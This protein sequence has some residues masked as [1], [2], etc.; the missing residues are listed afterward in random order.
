MHRDLVGGVEHAGRRAARLRRLARQPQAGERLGVRRLERERA[1]LRE[2]ERRHGHV[3]AIGMVQR[4][5]DRHPHVGV[6]EVRERG[7][8]AEPDER[9]HDRLR[10]HDDVDPVVRRA[11]QP[12]RLDHLEALVHQ[13]RRVDRDLAAHRPGRVPERVLDADPRELGQAAAAERA[14]RG[15]QR[16][17]LDRARPLAIDQLVQRRVL[18]VDRDQLRAGRL[19]RAPSPARRRRRATPCW[20][21]RRRS[22]R[23]APRSSARGRRSPRSRSA[24]G[25]RRTRPPAARAPQGRPAPRRRSRPPRRA[26]RRPRRSARSG[27]RRVRAPARPARRAS[28]RPRGRPART[29]RARAPRRRAP[30][31]RSSPS[32]RGSGVA[33]SRAQVWQG[34]PTP[35]LS[36]AAP[37]LLRL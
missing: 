27:R 32:S 30:A 26:R 25:R 13:R 3:D 33:S 5:G 21:A 6:P 16:Q 4:V 34:L 24:R 35:P 2:V 20:R 8:V 31:C 19:A 7:A 37:G 1:D 12:V 10:V 9:V 14:A 28:A 22:P 17:A 23:S 18:R 29:T 11:E 15:R 36:G